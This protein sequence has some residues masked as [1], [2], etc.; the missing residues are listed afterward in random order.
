MASIWR[1][2]ETQRKTPRKVLSLLG[3]TSVLRYRFGWLSLDS[4]LRSV[5]K[6]LGIHVAAVI[7][8]QPEAAVDVDSVADHT[9]LQ[10]RV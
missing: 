8:Q 2:V 4:A 1:E 6:R 7:L 5:S 10:A 9:A 3:L